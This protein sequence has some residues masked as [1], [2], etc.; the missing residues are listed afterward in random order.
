MNW[1]KWPMML[2]CATGFILGC[3]RPSA[4]PTAPGPAIKPGII[5]ATSHE[6]GDLSD[7]YRDQGGGVFNSGTGQITVTTEAAHSGRYAAKMEVWGID[8]DVQACRL[9]RWGENL[10]EGY[11][12][13][14][15]MFPVLP[16]VG[17]WLDIFEFKKRARQDSIRMVG[18]DSIRVATIDPTWYNEVETHPQGIALTLTHWNEA[19]NIPGVRPASVTPLIKAGKWFHIEWYY[20]DG[21]EDGIVKVWI[22]GE[23][24]WD[25]EGVNTRGVD[26]RIQWAPSLY[27]V[28]VNPSH[29]ILYVD[30]AVISTLRIGPEASLFSK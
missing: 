26:P 7:W 25:L 4:S 30:D 2:L 24:I 23:M 20:R 27:G 14:W 8:Q 6:T 9:F 11:F 3:S 16:E 13:A 18:Q 28:S 15:Y 21:V 17:G 5:W 12:S 22:N 1:Q 19:W 29:L 10:T